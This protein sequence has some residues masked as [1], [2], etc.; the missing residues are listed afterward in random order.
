[1]TAASGTAITRA[2]PNLGQPELNSHSPAPPATF[3]AGPDY[4]LAAARVKDALRA[5]ATPARPAAWSPTPPPPHANQQPS[6][7]HNQRGSYPMPRPN[8][9]TGETPGHSP[10]DPVRFFRD[11]SNGHASPSSNSPFSFVI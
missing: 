2:N 4:R 10:L 7:K 9:R 11:D 3:P 1:M 8:H 5:P 6:G